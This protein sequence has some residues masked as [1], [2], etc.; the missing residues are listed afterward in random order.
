M[1]DTRGINWG[2]TGAFTLSRR[3]SWAIGVFQ[4]PVWNVRL[5]ADS[6]F[7]EWRVDL[8]WLVA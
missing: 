8:E 7:W 2:Q 6:I 3:L 5:I 4:K 1:T